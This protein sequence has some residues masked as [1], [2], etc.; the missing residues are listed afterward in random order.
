MW[1]LINTLTNSQV[2]THSY[3]NKLLNLVNSQHTGNPE[4]M[5]NI[6]NDYFVAVGKHIAN[7]ITPPCSNKSPVAYNGP[8]HSFVLCEAFPEEA[9]AVI[10]RLLECKSVRM[11]DIPI[12][13][14]TS[15][16]AQVAKD[17]MC[18]KT[19]KHKQVAKD[20]RCDKTRP[21]SNNKLLSCN[22]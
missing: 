3:P 20:N 19:S 14:Q 11:N 18:D 7:S 21:T 15:S 9:E 10:D 5:A 1:K 8:D 16:K 22:Y 2:K 13:T 12:H 17:T 6:S 4:K